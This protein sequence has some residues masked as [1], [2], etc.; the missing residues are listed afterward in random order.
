MEHWNLTEIDAPAGTRDAHVL[1]QD[2]GG[3]AILIVLNPGQEL[4]EHQVKE[5]A[6]LT[7]VEGS[8][9]VTSGADTVDAG[10]GS[11]LRFDP[12]ERHAVAS[13]GGARIL[14]FL[15]PFPGPGHYRGGGQ[16]TH[17]PHDEF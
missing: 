17:P 12:D 16:G 3:R 9:R 8:V 14:L 5:D 1:R 6:W 11:L 4:G 13:E 10:V 7:V 15:A 2:D